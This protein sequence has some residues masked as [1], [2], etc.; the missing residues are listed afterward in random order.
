MV[1]GETSESCRSSLRHH[2]Q[3]FVGC[4]AMQ[5]FRGPLIRSPPATMIPDEAPNNPA[6]SPLL[7]ALTPTRY[8]HAPNVAHDPSKHSISRCQSRETVQRQRRG[9]TYCRFVCSLS[10]MFLTA[11][12]LNGPFTVSVDLADS[13][14]V[15]PCRLPSGL[16]LL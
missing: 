8:R 1:L 14:P 15:E 3:L 13:A 5:A 12:R 9:D 11:E 7:V 10:G 2:C 4:L 6:H 16:L